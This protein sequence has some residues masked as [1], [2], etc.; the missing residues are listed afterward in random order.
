MN[1]PVL[2]FVFS[3]GQCARCGYAYSARYVVIEIL[4]AIVFVSVWA[5]YGWQ[6]ITAVLCLYSGIFL[7]VSFIDLE[8]R[9]IPDLLSL[10]GWMG[11]LFIAL[12]APE[13]QFISFSEAVFAS[14]VGYLSFWLL[15]S[16]YQWITGE[17]G[18]GGGDVKLMGLIGALLGWKG[19]FLSILVGSVLGTVVGILSIIL[20]KKT[21]RFPIPFGPFLVL[22]AFTAMF[23]LEKFLIWF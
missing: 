23:G 8:F 5:N 14:I 10:G 7:A 17:D 16:G 18:L 9:I 20:F 19:V 12:I 21:K 4:T 6:P 22:G 15:S 13:G 1:I 3:A 11:A 2:S